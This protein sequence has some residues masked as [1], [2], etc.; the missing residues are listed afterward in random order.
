[1][2][3]SPRG[4]VEAVVADFYGRAVSD[5]LIGHQFRKIQAFAGADPLAPPLEAFA[6][7]LPRIVRFWTLHLPGAAGAAGA[8]PPAR[9]DAGRADGD[10]F[11]IVAVHRR[12]RLKKGELDRWMTLFHETLD[13]HE[14]SDPALVGAWRTKVE[15][16]RRVFL[17]RPRLVA[18]GG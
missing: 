2:R 7:H 6:G 8:G 9:G 4:L 16:F 18:R 17:E 5:V 10:G 1:M 12:L 14:G 13:A 11:N 15:E 3:S